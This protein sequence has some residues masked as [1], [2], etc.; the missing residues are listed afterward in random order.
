MF[1]ARLM[2]DELLMLEMTPDLLVGIPIRRILRKVEDMQAPLVFYEVL[3][4]LRS[5]WWSLIHHYNQMPSRMML[6][7]L[8]EELDYL[9]GCD[10]LVERSK[11]QVTSTADGRHRG[12][13]AALARHPNRRC[14]AARCPCLAEQCRQR[15]VRLVLKIQNRTV[16][17]DRSANPGDFGLQPFLAGLLVNLKIL[18]LR[19]LIRQARFAQSSPHGISRNDGTILTTQDL[20]YS[21][22]SPQVS[23]EA[24]CRRWLQDDLIPYVFRKLSQF[25]RAATAGAALQAGFTLRIIPLAPAKQRRSVHL[26]RRC[27]IYNTHSTPQSFN[28]SAPYLARRISASAHSERLVS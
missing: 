8:L 17:L 4:S 15:D 24:K 7:H 5:M 23:L 19:R 26:I 28:R 1:I 25:P 12:N 11:Q 18:S 2:G 20:M 9:G 16:F 21:P 27:G 14:L 10:P 22:H 3:G 6:Q 13:A